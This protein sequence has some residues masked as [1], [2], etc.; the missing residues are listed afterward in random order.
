MQMLANFPQNFSAS[1]PV[2]LTLG[3]L[4][5]GGG[6]GIAADILAIQANGAHAAP[7]ITA[8]TVQDTER[9][10]AFTPVAPTLLDTQARILARSLTITWVKAGMLASV[11]IVHWLQGWLA[12]T[13]LPLLL[14]PVLQAGGGGNLSNPDMLPALQ[15]LLPAVALLTPNGVEARQLAGVAPQTDLTTC[16]QV[17]Y[18]QGAQQILIT[19]GHET[20]THTVSNRF[21]Q[22]GHLVWEHTWPR[23]PGEFHGSGCTFAA[24][25]AAYLARGYPCLEAL[26][27]ASAYTQQ[28]L[29]QAYRIGP[30]QQIPRRHLS[31]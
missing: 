19:G 21:Y 7:L 8:L 31:C 18:A 5:P 20:D 3:G 14:D 11:P 23:L 2:V 9:A 1:R 10:Y 26:Q 17:L 13:G 28:T 16:A 4:D 29:M 12:E 6:A 27:H 25:L 30:G 24:S 22:Q 15:A